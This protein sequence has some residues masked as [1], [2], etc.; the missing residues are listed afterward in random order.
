MAKRSVKK[1]K[2]S[3]SSKIPVEVKV[4]SVLYYVLAVLS[5]I[6]GI[7]FLVGAGAIGEYTQQIPAL[8]VLGTGLFIVLGIIVIAFAVLD[9]F[10]GRGLWKG[11]NWARIIA[12]IIAILGF[13]SALLSL[14]DGQF[15]S[16]ISLV[17]HGLIGGYLLFSKEVKKTFK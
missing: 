7:L 14:V 6:F 10:I 11:K 13:I 12:I 3:S 16:I 15:L 9:F 17:I 1:V 2:P 5:L 8:A 4:I